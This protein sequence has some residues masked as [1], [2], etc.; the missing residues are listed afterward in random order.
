[1]A[2]ILA[3]VFAA[4]ETMTPLMASDVIVRRP[5]NTKQWVACQLQFSM[6]LAAVDE[7]V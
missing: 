5:R 7:K 4:V 3:A 1:M 2:G 6:R